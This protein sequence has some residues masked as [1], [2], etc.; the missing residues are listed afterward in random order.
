MKLLTG[1]RFGLISLV[2]GVGI[3]AGGIAYA[4][5]PD[6]N[7]VIHG[8]YVKTTGDLRVIDS[9]GK[10]CDP[11]EKPLEW[12]QA[13]PTGPSGTAGPTSLQ[14]GTAIVTSATVTVVTHTVTAAEAGLTILTAPFEVE[15]LNGTTG[16]TTSVLCNIAI[17]GGGGGFLVTVSD[18]GSAAQ[19]D[20]TSMTITGRRTLAAGDVVTVD[21]NTILAGDSGEAEVQATLLL[22]RVGS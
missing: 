16:G 4:S 6:S 20:T 15:D 14:D 3:A 11:G 1:R 5:I 2:V 21:C 9:S 13:G 8:C 7:G 17:N 18:N 22:E 19:G 10:G 12:N